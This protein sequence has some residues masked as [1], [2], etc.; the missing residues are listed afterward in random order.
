[1]NQPVFWTPM[2]RLAVVPV[3]IAGVIGLLLC[4]VLVL[5]LLL[6]G[7]MPAKAIR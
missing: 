3:V 1:M 2:M 7:M 5:G 4:A 6:L